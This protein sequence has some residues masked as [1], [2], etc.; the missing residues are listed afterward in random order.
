MLSVVCGGESAERSGGEEYSLSREPA[1]AAISVCV[2][3]VR[4]GVSEVI[5]GGV[6]PV[7]RS[8]IGL[9]GVLLGGRNVLSV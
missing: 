7:G 3:A 6:V 1:L 9:L 5:T 4:D 2:S 8:P